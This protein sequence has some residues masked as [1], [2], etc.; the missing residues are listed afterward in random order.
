VELQESLFSCLIV[1]VGL[2]N[3]LILT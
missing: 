3:D 1:L 2:N